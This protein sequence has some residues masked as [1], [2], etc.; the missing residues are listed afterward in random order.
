MPRFW[1]RHETEEDCSS[2]D[3][4]NAPKGIGP[5]TRDIDELSTRGRA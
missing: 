3:V 4:T 5:I 1:V 2:T